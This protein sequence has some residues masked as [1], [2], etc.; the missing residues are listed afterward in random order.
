MLHHV[1]KH[2]KAKGLKNDFL[3]IVLYFFVFTTPLFE[4]PQAYVIYSNKSADG[5]AV[6]TWFY[7]AISSVVWLIYGLRK[8]LKPV[9]I[10]YSFYI[11]TET[12]VVIGILIYS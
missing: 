2:K 10:A 4:L 9:I 3:D 7:F 6:L 5:V 11:V 1:H 12:A 8:K